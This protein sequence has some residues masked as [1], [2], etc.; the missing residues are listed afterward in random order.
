M[1]GFQHTH[2]NSSP[3]N[4]TCVRHPRPVLTRGCLRTDRVLQ[5]WSKQSYSCQ[6]GLCAAKAWMLLLA[7]F[8]HD[9]YVTTFTPFIKCC[10]SFSLSHCLFSPLPTSPSLSC[11]PSF[12]SANLS[13]YSSLYMYVCLNSLIHSLSSLPVPPS[14]P[15]SLLSPHSPPLSPP[16]PWQVPILPVAAGLQ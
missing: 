14:P 16:E 10:M 9:H 3:Y 7:P 6:P 2:A 15:P 1:N 12:P 13:P 5:L 11:L 4:P 8:I